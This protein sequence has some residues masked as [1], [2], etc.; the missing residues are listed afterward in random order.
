M[1][2]AARMR[3]VQY[4]ICKA[5]ARQHMESGWQGLQSKELEKERERGGEAIGGGGGRGQ[6]KQGWL[7]GC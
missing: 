1:Q 2:K 4:C 6:L 5:G 3:H 7:M